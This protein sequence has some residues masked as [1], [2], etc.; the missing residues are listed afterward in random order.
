MVFDFRGIS[1][2]ECLAYILVGERDAC[3]VFG[4]V[5]ATVLFLMDVGLLV[6]W[7]KVSGS[8]ALKEKR[9][10]CFKAKF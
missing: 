4:G 8:A 1:G 2:F 5:K 3:G 9:L 10:S 7:D 6:P